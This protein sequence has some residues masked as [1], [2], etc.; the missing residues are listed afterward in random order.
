M[1]QHSDVFRLDERSALVTGAG[2]GLGQAIAR[3]FAAAGAAVLVTDIDKDA[4]L[5][6]AESITAVGGDR[7]HGRHRGVLVDIG[8]QHRG[9]GGG[10]GTGDRLADT[11][12]RTGHQRRA[13]VE[14][15]HVTPRHQ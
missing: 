1:T 8:H 3:A 9:P 13:P 7:F 12:A 2:S 15:E 6:T 11:A 10:E 5:A 4:A 14:P